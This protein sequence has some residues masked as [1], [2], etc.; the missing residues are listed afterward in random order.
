MQ[1]IFSGWFGRSRVGWCALARVLVL[2]FLAAGCGSSGSEG[3]PKLP[4][5]VI[6]VEELLVDVGERFE[7]SGES[8]TDPEAGKDSEPDFFWTALN[9]VVTVSFDDRC[10]EDIDQICEENSDDLCAEAQVQACATNAD[11]AVGDCDSK[12]SQCEE[13]QNR[14]CNSDEDCDTG[15]CRFNSGTS[16]PDCEEGICVIGGGNDLPIAS[17]LASAPGPYGVRLLVEGRKSN[18][19]G[20]RTLQTYPSLY[21]LGSMIAFGGT[22][23]GL[24]GELSDVDRYAPNAV[25]GVGNP[26]SGNILLADPVIG[27]IREFD[28]Q[29]GNILGTFGETANATAPIALA[30]DATDDLY[31]VN[32]DGT[33]QIYDG[34][35]GL[36]AGN[37]ADVTLGAEEV[38]SIVFAPATGNLLVV[39]GRAGQ[40]LREFDGETGA[41]LG[42]YGTTAAAVG[43]AVDAAFLSAADGGGLLIAD[44]T[45]DVKRCRANGTACQSFGTVASLL[46]AGGPTA[47]AVNPSAE[48][49]P[50]SAV[51][52]AD[53]TNEYVI[54]C[55]SDGA[56][57]E[58]FGDTAGL[59]SG[60]VDVFF[61]P[62][63]TPIPDTTTTST[64]T[65]TLP[66]E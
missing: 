53:R 22:N 42:L 36:F 59:D 61:A 45:G 43:Q 62:P 29:S 66:D 44:A 10:E 34:A 63:E 9:N 21:V 28:F 20:L 56:T 25:R 3:N 17:F 60:Y 48:F 12:A 8:S 52:I 57:C 30:F 11:C 16:S 51:L 32:Q 54:A 37:F 55:T 19:V 1:L 24:V 65:T 47:V 40:G 18:N 13:L 46:A 58:V 31:V 50:D 35:S 38:I 2:V 64:T 23:G 33:V 6:D 27:S 26:V 4:V 41:F 7:L 15:P 14:T 5:V 39:D 49:E